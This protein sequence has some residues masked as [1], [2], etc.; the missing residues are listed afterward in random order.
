MFFVLSGCVEDAGFET[1]A[2]VF[3]EPRA[4]VGLALRLAQMMKRADF[5]AIVRALPYRGRAGKR[6]LR[7]SRMAVSTSR[8]TAG[9]GTPLPRRPADVSGN[10]GGRPR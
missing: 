6:E 10:A 7:V 4:Q 3:V 1:E 5:S 2:E 8:R 9:A